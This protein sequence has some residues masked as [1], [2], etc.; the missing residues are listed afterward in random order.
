MIWRVNRKLIESSIMEKKDIGIYTKLGVPYNASISRDG[1]STC[2]SC[3]CYP[4]M[5]GAIT[6]VFLGMDGRKP[7][8]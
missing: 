2:T 8:L 7:M 5:E 1:R 6:L 4:D 3:H